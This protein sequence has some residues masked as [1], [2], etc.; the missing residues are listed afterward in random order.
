M[1]NLLQVFQ[2]DWK[3]VIRDTTGSKKFMLTNI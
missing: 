3:C 1:H 2:S